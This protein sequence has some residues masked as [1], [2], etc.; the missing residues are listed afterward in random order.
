[1]I[2][3]KTIDA[4]I[5]AAPEAARARLRELRAAVR[6]GAPSAE[7]GVKW[8]LPAFSTSRILVMFGAFKKHVGLF[9]TAAVLK[10]HAKELA[11]YDGTSGG[12]KFPLDKPIPAALVTKLTKVRVKDNAKNDALWKTGGVK[13]KPAA[14]RKR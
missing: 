7:E 1:M 2:K 3:A 8:G 12:V 9:P 14:K 4:Y 11:K 10:A 5:A 6:K 13:K